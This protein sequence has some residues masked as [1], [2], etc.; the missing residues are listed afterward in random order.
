MGRELNAYERALAEDRRVIREMLRVTT[1]GAHVG[2]AVTVLMVALFAAF[3]GARS[4]LTVGG[5]V[6]AWFALTL[7]VVIFRGR[8]RWAAVTR[9]Y[10]LTFGW[11]GWL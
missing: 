6:A 5:A 7:M 3:G 8:R 11:G 1:G 4:A 10:V 9:A 2:L